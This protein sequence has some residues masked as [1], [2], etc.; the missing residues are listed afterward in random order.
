MYMDVLSAFTCI[1]CVSGACRGQERLSD[2]LEL[3]LQMTVGHY[4]GAES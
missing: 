1:N 4:I 2:A 3:K